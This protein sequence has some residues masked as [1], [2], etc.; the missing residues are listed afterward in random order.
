MPAL[1]LHKSWTLELTTEELRLVLRALG[2]RIDDQSIDPI[3]RAQC[4]Q[5]G[6]RI[7]E[8]RGKVLQAT[9]RDGDRLVD[10]AAS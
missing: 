1:T 4:H 5:L 3:M 7:T 9:A 2:G 10:A 6:D 8:L